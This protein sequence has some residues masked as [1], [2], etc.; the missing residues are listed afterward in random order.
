MHTAR[1]TKCHRAFGNRSLCRLCSKTDLVWQRKTNSWSLL[2]LNQNCFRP[3][4]SMISFSTKKTLAEIR[5]QIWIKF[6]WLVVLIGYI[7]TA[8]K[9]DPNP[10]IFCSVNSTNYMQSDRFGLV[11]TI[12]PYIICVHIHLP[13]CGEF[14]WHSIMT[15]HNAESTI[16]IRQT[17]L[18]GDRTLKLVVLN[19]KNGPS[20]F[21][22]LKQDTFWCS[23]MFIS[24]Y[25]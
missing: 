24:C 5:T 15:N 14:D 21:P 16:F 17:S 20:I 10:H 6:E 11:Q 7:H 12:S 23:F 22:R 3:T 1:A 13:L 2:M 8:R 18:T 4:F 19:F 25:N 9:C